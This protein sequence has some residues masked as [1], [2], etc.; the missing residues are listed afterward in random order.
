MSNPIPSNCN[1]I[2]FKEPGFQL[3]LNWIL[4]FPAAGLDLP[5][6]EIRKI[7]EALK[8]S[9]PQ[10]KVDVDT[11]V[12]K[13]RGLQLMR[14]NFRNFYSSFATLPPTAMRK[15]EL[16][17]SYTQGSILIVDLGC[18]SGILGDAILCKNPQAQILALDIAAHHY[19][20][21]P[22]NCFHLMEDPEKIPL[23]KEVAD[24][25]ILSF[26]LHHLQVDTIGYL[27]EVARILKKNGKAL[28]LEDTF[29]ESQV[30]S[31]GDSLMQQFF[32]LENNSERINFLIFCDYFTHSFLNHLRQYRPTV[33]YHTMEEW[34]NFFA[35]TGFIYRRIS[36]L[37]F[38]PLGSRNPVSRAFFVFEKSVV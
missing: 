4:R 17:Y 32:S 12:A 27:R 36:Y 2:L 24:V 16:F 13:F 9:P 33:N 37:G 14:E 23:G 20:S 29:P 22:K 28:V 35:Q 11:M 1:A 21:H 31:E 7:L 34:V 18:G 25:V 15:A 3:A 8:V 6:W 26:M 38:E 19:N 30:P 10:D 5:V